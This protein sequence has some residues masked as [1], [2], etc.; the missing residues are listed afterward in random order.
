MLRRQGQGECSASIVLFWVEKARGAHSTSILSFWMQKGHGAYSTSIH[1]SNTSLIRY[2]IPLQRQPPNTPVHRYT[3]HP[4]TFYSSLFHTALPLS[5]LYPFFQP[6]LLNSLYKPT[7]GP[8]HPLDTSGPS[9]A[10]EALCTPCT[11]NPTSRF[12]PILVAW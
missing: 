8:I 5:S 11:Q 1:L 6:I 2:P 4:Q 7:R 12:W 9:R 3:L 10:E